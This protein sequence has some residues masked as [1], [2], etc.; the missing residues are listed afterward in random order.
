MIVT[1]GGELTVTLSNSTLTGTVNGAAMSLDKNS[2][3]NVTGD[4]VLT[5][6]RNTGVISGTTV[7]NIYGNGH[8]VYYDKNH[9]GNKDLGGKSYGLGGGGTLKPSK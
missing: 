5:S 7:T 3:W 9:D 1:E 6:L 8:T 2:K 4:S